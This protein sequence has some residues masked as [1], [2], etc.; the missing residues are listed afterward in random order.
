MLKKSNH[1]TQSQALR[2]EQAVLEASLAAARQTVDGWVAKR[3]QALLKEDDAGVDDVEE[4]FFNARRLVERLELQRSDLATRLEAAEAAERLAQ[5]QQF[6]A[7]ARH[8]A[9]RLAGIRRRRV[10]LFAEDTELARDDEAIDIIVR[11]ANVL[12]REIGAPKIVA[13]V[14]DGPVIQRFRQPADE[15]AVHERLKQLREAAAA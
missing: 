11:E 1:Q 6:V 5:K 8:Q 15:R 10:E 14:T 2:R 12:A 9:E 4:E 13:P 3:A 7:N